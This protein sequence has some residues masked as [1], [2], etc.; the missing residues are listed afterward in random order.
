[1]SETIEFTP[2]VKIFFIIMFGLFLSILII[3]TMENKS[4]EENE[5]IKK[6]CQ[7]PFLYDCEDLKNVSEKCESAKF[8]YEKKCPD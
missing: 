3:D 8:E 1:M 6:V 7:Q 4:K 5:K 2:K